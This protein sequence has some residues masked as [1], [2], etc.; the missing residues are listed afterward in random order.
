LTNTSDLKHAE[1]VLQ[2]FVENDQIKYAWKTP[3]LVKAIVDIY[4]DRIN[5]ELLKRVKETMK[6]L[7]KKI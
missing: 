3:T 6:G 1:A 4:R 7:G 2:A 5:A